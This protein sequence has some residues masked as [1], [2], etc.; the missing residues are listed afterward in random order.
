MGF[1]P[2]RARE[3]WQ[4]TA[5]WDNPDV[6]LSRRPIDP[7]DRRLRIAARLGSPQQ[8]DLA[9][10]GYGQLVGFTAYADLIKALT[11]NMVD[12]AVVPLSVYE[13]QRGLWPVDTV[14]T[15]G[16]ARR[17]GFYLPPADPK[18]L[19]AA[20]NR[21]IERCRGSAAT[22]RAPVPPASASPPRPSQA[23]TAS[24]AVS[25]LRMRGPSPT[26]RNPA[27]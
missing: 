11:L 20:L 3:L 27:A 8:A 15:A 12:A 18:G 9:A 6:W 24:G 14:Q 4:S 17:S 5:A 23:S 16:Q 2:E 26:G 21:A 25:A 10:D 19:G 22:Q 1:T 13:D 7:S